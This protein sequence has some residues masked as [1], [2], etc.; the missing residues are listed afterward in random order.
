MVE[1]EGDVQ[2]IP[3]LAKRVLKDCFGSQCELRVSLNSIRVGNLANLAGHRVETWLRQLQL[4][5][6]VRERIAGIVLLLDGDTKWTTDLAGKKIRFCPGIAARL[7]AAESR[8]VGGGDVFS[9]AI[10]F[11]CPEFESWLIA[12]RAGFAGELKPD[13]EPPVEVETIRDAKKW[14]RLARHDG[15]RPTLHQLALANG[16]SLDGMR[17]LRSF[18]RFEK[19]LKLLVEAHAHNQRIVTP[20]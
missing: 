10:V 1:G 2:A 17:T 20:E 13:V 5:I 3:A 6:R 8:K 18:R 19:T 16:A 15:Y 14:L 9:V 11:A 4:S 12:G 7:L